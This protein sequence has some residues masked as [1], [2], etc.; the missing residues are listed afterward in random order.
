MHQQMYALMSVVLVFAS[1]RIL[2]LGKTFM[3]RTQSPASLLVRSLVDPD[4]VLARTAAGPG[5]NNNQEAKPTKRKQAI[6]RK[7]EKRGKV[8]E[9]VKTPEGHPAPPPAGASSSDAMPDLSLPPL[10]AVRNLD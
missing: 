10:G 3:A 2:G 5:R 4:F 6:K 9:K 8:A 1:G 7:A